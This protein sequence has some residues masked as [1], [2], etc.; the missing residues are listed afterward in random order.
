MKINEAVAAMGVNVER[1]IAHWVQKETILWAKENPTESP[2]G[3]ALSVSA[4]KQSW[5]LE[6]LPEEHF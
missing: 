3:W 6:G 2:Q 1:F 4:P 5:G